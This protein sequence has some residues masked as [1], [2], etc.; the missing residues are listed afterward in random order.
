LKKLQETLTLRKKNSKK[1]L[2]KTTVKTIG[3][4][5]MH[6][7]IILT[8]FLFATYFNTKAQTQLGLR[9]GKTFS[10]VY[11]VPLKNLEWQSGNSFALV[12]NHFSKPHLTN[13]HAIM[14]FPQHYFVST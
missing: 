12:F 8:I 9:V 5:I 1:T 10:Q 3:D 4:I 11:F 7:K 6:T 13:R 2:Q 14:L